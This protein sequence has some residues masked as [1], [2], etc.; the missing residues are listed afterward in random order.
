LLSASRNLASHQPPPPPRTRSKARSPPCTGN[1]RLVR[2][3]R[4]SSNVRHRDCSAAQP[5]SAQIRAGISQI[6]NN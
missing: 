4:T 3:P 1:S 2:S 6:Y 5:N